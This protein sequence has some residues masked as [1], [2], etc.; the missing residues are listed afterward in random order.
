MDELNAWD[1][2]GFTEEQIMGICKEIY[3]IGE[4]VNRSYTALTEPILW[5]DDP[6][7]LYVARGCGLCYNGQN[8]IGQKFQKA[9]YM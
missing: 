5:N 9:Y 8:P 3:P 1:A 2:E 6:F 7:R 4:E